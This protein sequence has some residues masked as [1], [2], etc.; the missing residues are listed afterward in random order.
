VH[1][2]LLGAPILGDERYGGGRGSL[3]LLARTIHVPLDPPVDA[4]APPPIHMLA[5]LEQCGFRG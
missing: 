1:C 4:T 3:H 2:T 5:T